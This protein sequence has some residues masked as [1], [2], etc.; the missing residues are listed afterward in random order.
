MNVL[1]IGNRE[2]VVGEF[3]RCPMSGRKDGTPCWI[4][5]QGNYQYCTAV[6]TGS[7][8]ETFSVYGSCG[9]RNCRRFGRRATYGKIGN[10]GPS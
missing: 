4:L 7:D 5:F 3:L 2:L 9:S 6:R 1:M 10:A 8:E